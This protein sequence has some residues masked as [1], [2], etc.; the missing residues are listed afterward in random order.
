MRHPVSDHTPRQMTR[1]AFMTAALGVSTTA[2][3]AGCGRLIPSAPTPREL[4]KVAVGY[5]PV[6]ISAP[7]YIA[8]EKGYFREAG[9]AVELKDLWQ[10]SEML[11]GLAAGEL[12]GGTGGVGAALMNAINRGLEVKLVAPLHSE[13][14]PVATPL[15]VAKSLWEK[16]TVKKV[17]DLKG[18]KVAINS[19]GSAT[20]Y[21]LAAALE[22]GGLGLRD[23]E[24]QTMPFPDAVTAMENGALEASMLSEPVA[25]LGER[26]GSTVRLSEDFI[27]DFQVTAVYFTTKFISENK[28]AGEAFV[29]GYLR[30]VRDLQG[31]KYRAPENLTILEKYTK[32]PGDL[33]AASR[34]PFHDPEGKVRVE[35]FQKLHDF[36]MKEGSLNFKEPLNMAKLTEASFAEA[37]RKK[38]G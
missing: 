8:Q 16:G 17:A 31:D 32:V 22:K 14:P 5:V 3:L 37:A 13:K 9:V 15:C 10:A 7:L 23:I 29:T 1:R 34:L 24:L 19:K 21:W 26:K 20:E 25:T 33:I 18:K 35:D 27:N 2:L 11:A 6:L 12:Q 38:L 28:A 4:P 36:F 30:A